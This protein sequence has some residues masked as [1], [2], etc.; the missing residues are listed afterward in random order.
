LSKL[1]LKDAIAIMSASAE[2]TAE[3]GMSCSLLH[4][5]PD[6]RPVYSKVGGY[7]SVRSEW[8]VAPIKLHH[9]TA[10]P[11]QS[12]ADSDSSN[13]WCV[14]Q[15]TFPEDA[16]QLQQLHKQHS[17]NRFITIV[18]SLQY[19]KE[20]VSA[21]LGG[22]LWVLSA[23]PSAGNGTEGDGDQG[24]IVA[25]MSLR[26]R[27]ERYQLR[28]F[29]V[30]ESTTNNSV[31]TTSAMKRLLGAA[32]DQADEKLDVEESEVSLLLPTYVLSQMKHEMNANGASDAALF[33][34]VDDATEENDDGWMYVNFNQLQP[35][36]L[37]L[38]EREIDPIPHLIWPTDSF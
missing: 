8:S 16:R 5:S 12:G 3:G 22:T 15:A 13:G 9:L 27:G 30:D 31:S 7:E 24:G 26:K 38:T 17:E 20:Y 33:L 36:V 37:E 35:S 18:R 11:Q 4:A 34:N 6:F 19:W 21:E 32:L 29:G 23:K 2:N 25:W 28:E 14:R 1:L 10:R